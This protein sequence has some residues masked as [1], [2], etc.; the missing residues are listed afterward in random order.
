MTRP[1]RIS[2]AINEGKKIRPLFLS[3]HY[4]R[5]IIITVWKMNNCRSLNLNTA[6]HIFVGFMIFNSGMASIADVAFSVAL[7]LNQ[8]IA[9]IMRYFNNVI[10][11]LPL[12]RSNCRIKYGYHFV[13]SLIVIQPI[14]I[15]DTIL[16]FSSQLGKVV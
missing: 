16:T 1:M 3:L 15:A 10:Y 12:C 6:F 2:N 14:R 7:K 11:A 5:P 13:F 8:F 4:M 9:Q